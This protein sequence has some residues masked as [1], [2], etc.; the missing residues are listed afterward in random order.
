MNTIIENALICNGYRVMN[1]NMS[2]I[3]F[4]IKEKDEH[5]SIVL[6]AD[7]E[8]SQI[9]AQLYNEIIEQI[10]KKYIQM[11]KRVNFTGFLVCSDADDA[12]DI[13]MEEKRESADENKGYDRRYVVRRSDGEIILFEFQNDDDEVLK[14][15]SDMRDKQDAPYDAKTSQVQIKYKKNNRTLNKRYDLPV[16][17]TICNSIIIIVNILVFIWMEINGNTMDAQYLYE[18]GGS[19]WA[20]VVNDHEYYRLLTAMFIHSGMDHLAGNMLSLL[21][22]GSYLEKAVGSKK[23]LLVYFTSGILAG[24]TSVVYNM[25]AGNDVVC[26]GASGAIFGVIGAVIAV[27]F[28]NDGTYMKRNM[29][30]LLLY[31]VMSILV[32]VTSWD[33][34]NS[35]HI[36]GVIS[37]FLCM[38]VLLKL[39]PDRN[40]KR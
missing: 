33:I 21:F 24:V 32:G 12:A 29:Q 19:Y 14:I 23:Y 2:D 27:L 11:G 9:T 1:S 26:V 22:I 20:N 3:D 16:D 38:Y 28:L 35:A 39:Y 34:D 8:I 6:M 40:Y 18:K 31:A 7:I 37:G 10:Y 30:R 15:I 5:I 4:F 36:G 13:C 17:L 25:N